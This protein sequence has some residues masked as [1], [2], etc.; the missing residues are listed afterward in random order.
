MVQAFPRPLLVMG[1]VT[2]LGEYPTMRVLIPYPERLHQWL[3]ASPEQQAVM[4]LTARSESMS[5]LKEQAKFQGPMKTIY[6]S[7]G[8][9]PVNATAI[10]GEQATGKYKGYPSM[11]VYVGDK[12]IGTLAGRY[13]EEERASFDSVAA[14][15][16]MRVI[17]RESQF[18][19]GYYASGYFPNV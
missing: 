4:D 13:F 14:G 9:R 3:V 8:D 5:R 15:R 16:P 11:S 10:I 19:D 2:E 1:E 18:S 6:E 12:L 17:V 7:H